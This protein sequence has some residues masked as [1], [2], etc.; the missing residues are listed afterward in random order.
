MSRSDDK[1]FMNTLDMALS[2]GD[3]DLLSEMLGWDEDDEELD[4]E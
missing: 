3:F 2:E 1:E 4:A